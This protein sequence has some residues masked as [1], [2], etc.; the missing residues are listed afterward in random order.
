MAA[1]PVVTLEM[2]A[3]DK[4][5]NNS[6]VLKETL[7]RVFVIVITFYKYVI[8][9]PKQTATDHVILKP[10]VEKPLKQFT[11][12]LRSYSDLGREHSL[13]SIATPG[14]GNDNT[15]IILP[16]PPN[17]CAVCINQEEIAFKVD[18]E[19]LDWKDTCVAWDS[20]TGLVQLWINGKRY[21]RRITTTRTPIGPQMS[22]ILGQEQDSFGG[23]FDAGQ[24]F[25]GEISDVNM[26]DYVLSSETM[27][28][29]FHGYYYIPGNS[30]NWF[31]E[32]YVIKG[33]PLS[34]K[35]NDEL[36]SMNT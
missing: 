6:I 14:S 26:W 2:A 21:P 36:K 7:Q 8:I 15:F 5:W 32:T 35:K 28:D 11:V 19:V 20:E 25:V 1:L 34:L 3:T 22:V 24:S 29:F 30:F 17:S 9:F 10:T 31:D 16:R 27:K 33:A 13:F 18:P 4:L 12:C 23:G